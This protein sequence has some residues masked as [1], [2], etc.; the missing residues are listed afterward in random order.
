MSMTIT[1]DPMELMNTAL[2]L[3]TSAVELDDVGSTLRACTSCPMPPDVRNSVDAVVATLD[4]VLDD[5]AAQLRNEGS[6]LAR[7]AVV[8][9]N[10]MLTAAGY[11][12]LPGTTTI[13]SSDLTGAGIVG[14]NNFSGSITTSAD[15]L[16]SGLVGGSTFSSAITT[17][18]GLGGSFI[19]GGN[20]FSSAI[21]TSPGVSGAGIIGGGTRWDGIAGL[22]VAI[23]EARQNSQERLTRALNAASASGAS[24]PAGTFPMPGALSLASI[25]SFS[26]PF[27]RPSEG[28]ILIRE[29]N[30][31]GRRIPYLTQSEKEWFGV[32]G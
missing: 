26:N 5:M 32:V 11:P 10:D 23:A 1:I 13:T 7:R 30:R 2:L 9:A 20:N 22:G 15:L 17:S 4:R 8:A 18:P 6:N 25:P 31:T 27:L 24:I 16:G 21:T 12:P 19:I 28:D 3:G 29:E 14:G